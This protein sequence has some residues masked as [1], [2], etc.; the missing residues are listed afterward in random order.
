MTIAT[1]SYVYIRETLVSYSCKAWT[2]YTASFIIINYYRSPEGKRITIDCYF[3]LI[4]ILRYAQRLRFV[5]TK[6]SS[7][8][9]LSSPSK[10]WNVLLI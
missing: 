6:D 4:Y 2:G 9:P 3:C 10:T 5:S 7:I 1:I 8:I